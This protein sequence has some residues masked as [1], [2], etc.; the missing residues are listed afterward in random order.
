MS[1][2]TKRPPA[3]K[4]LSETIRKGGVAHNPPPKDPPAKPVSGVS[5]P[6]KK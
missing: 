6:Q 2:T 5:Q 1:R 4:P 3:E